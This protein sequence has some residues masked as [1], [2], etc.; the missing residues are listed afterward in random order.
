MID[1]NIFPYH[2]D[3]VNTKIRELVEQSGLSSR[4][5]E[6]AL[7][8]SKRSLFNLSNGLRRPN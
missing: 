7:G 4:Q 6:R 1:K 3:N 8:V 2:G 5:V